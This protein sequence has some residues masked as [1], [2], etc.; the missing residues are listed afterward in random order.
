MKQS[1]NIRELAYE[2][3]LAVQKDGR[4]SHLVLQEF[5]QKSETRTDAAARDRA[6]LT[7]LVE[8]TIEYALQLDYV[9]GQ[10]SRTP[11]RRIKTQ[12]LVILRLAAYQILYMDAVPDRAAVNE[13][14]NLTAKK[15]FGGLRGFVNG[16]L[17]TL[18]RNKDTIVWPDPEIDA[19]AYISVRCS[20][21]KEIVSAWINR[22][23]FEKTEAICRSFLENVPVCVH[24][25]SGTL[26]DRY[27]PSGYLADAWFLKATER[28]LTELDDFREGRIYIQDLS[29]QIALYSAGIR[30]GDTVLDLCAA[31]GG[32]SLLAA[33]LCRSS[34]PD[35]SDGGWVLSYDLT[36]EKTDLIR[37]NCRRC[38]MP[39][40]RIGTADAR[41]FD[42]AL[43][44]Q[45][46]VVIADLP[47]SGFG[48]AGKK[49]EIKYKNYKET[50]AALSGLQKQ[51]LENA[52]R[53]VRPGGKLL[54]STC[55]IA[56]EENEDNAAWLTRQFGFM[57]VDLRKNLPEKLQSIPTAQ[58]GYVQLLPG[59]GP[60]DGFF[61][62]LFVR[63]D[64][65]EGNS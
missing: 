38:H 22:Y 59:D 16:V 57:P 26:S 60:W 12:I 63:P 34:D 45:F 61:F 55:T 37:E 64:T 27:C 56:V 33:G 10:F 53:Y 30:P 43:E 41:Q 4:Q 29:S 3:L 17:R 19:A 50:V 7:R 20:I 40:I 62:S 25:I 32:K 13:A 31:P 35:S 52:V 1:F 6:F 36:D 18:A 51:I 39:N 9:I 49:P 21:A 58:K 47:C 28:S 54:Y 48:V 46:D 23:G 44:A 15:G 2:A 5:V 8:G 65:Q 14:V 24:R 42:P 11:V